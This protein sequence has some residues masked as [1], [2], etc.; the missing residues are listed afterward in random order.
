[1]CRS[2]YYEELNHLFPEAHLL[3]STTQWYYHVH[4]DHAITIWCNCGDNNINRLQK[5]QNMVMRIIFGAPFRTHINDMLRS[6][7]FMSVRDRIT[8]ATACMMYKVC[9]ILLPFYINRQ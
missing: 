5:L 6:L 3:L 2:C 1:M 8:F 7:G 4:F 9:I